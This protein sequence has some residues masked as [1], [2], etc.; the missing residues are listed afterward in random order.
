MNAE[1]SAEIR[2]VLDAL[3]T[4][5][6]SGADSVTAAETALLDVLALDGVEPEDVPHTLP[7]LALGLRGRA[8]DAGR[9]DEVAALDALIAQHGWIER[10]VAEMVATRGPGHFPSPSTR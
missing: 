2:V 1:L 8:E 5:L 9:K 3:A 6:G 10:Q 7:F 4:R